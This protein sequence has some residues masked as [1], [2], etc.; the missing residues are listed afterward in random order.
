MFDGPDGLKALIAPE[1]ECSTPFPFVE[2]SDPPPTPARVGLYFE[3]LVNLWLTRGLQLKMEAR[4]RQV[5]EGKRT[6]GEIDFCV[7]DQKGIRWHLESTIKFYL[8]HPSTASTHGSSFIG[9]DPRDSF[10]RKHQHLIERQLK[11][12]IPELPSVDHA[13]PVSRGI[14]FYHASEPNLRD[15]PAGANPEHQRGLWMRASDWC[16]NL[17]HDVEQVVRLPKPYW[18]SGLMNPTITDEVL[19]WQE[20]E[21]HIRS[22]FQQSKAPLMLSL[23]TAENEPQSETHRCIVVHDTWPTIRP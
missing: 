13:L 22:H 4:H 23:R 9:P 7:Q 17:V 11:L 3:S 19:S 18:L 1:K 21:I 6:V 10:E 14:L 16:K 20:S 12:N 15:R 2:S 8:H 5:F